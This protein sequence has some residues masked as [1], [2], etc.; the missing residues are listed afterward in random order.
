MMAGHELPA[1]P[2]GFLST[3]GI[4]QNEGQYRE[5]VGLKESREEEVRPVGRGMMGRQSGLSTSTLVVRVL[6]LTGV[7][8]SSSSSSSRQ[9]RL[10]SHN[11]ARPVQPGGLHSPKSRDGCYFYCDAVRLTRPSHFNAQR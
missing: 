9:W 2:S 5:F 3:I 7:Y 8:S 1:V 10:A 11:S 6:V 4:A